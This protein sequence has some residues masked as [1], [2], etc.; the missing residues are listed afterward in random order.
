MYGAATVVMTTA[1]RTALKVAPDSTPATR[2]RFTTTMPTSPRGTIPIPTAIDDHRP[3]VQAPPIPPTSLV[4][5]PM[6]ASA[7]ARPATAGSS[8]APRSSWAPVTAK[9]KGMKI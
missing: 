8:N 3:V 1:T 6:T 4:R 9:K 5:T 7:T 2:P